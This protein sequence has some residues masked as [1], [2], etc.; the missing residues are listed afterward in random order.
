LLRDHSLFGF[1]GI[2]DETKDAEGNVVRT[3]SIITTAANDLVSDVH[4]RMPVI[5]PRT[6]ESLWLDNRHFDLEEL[7]KLFQPYPSELMEMYPVSDLVNSVKNNSAACLEPRGEQPM[8]DVSATSAPT[9]KKRTRSK[10]RKDSESA[11]TVDMDGET[12]A[13]AD[14]LEDQCHSQM[15]IAFN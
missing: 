2:Y 8:E 15:K 11:P 1:A 7:K 10:S 5:L 6:A 13:H 12:H 3:C 4:D 14:A 9:K